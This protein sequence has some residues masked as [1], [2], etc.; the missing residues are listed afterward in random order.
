VRT[1]APTPRFVA[2]TRRT[3]R[4]PPFWRSPGHRAI[5]APWIAIPL[6]LSSPTP[7]SPPS[8]L[9]CSARTTGFS[10]PRLLARVA[11]LDALAATPDFFT[12]PDASALWTEREAAAELVQGVDHL[13]DA[14]HTLVALDALARAEHDD[15]LDA[16]LH[17]ETAALWAQHAALQRRLALT[18]P[19]DTADAIVELSSGAGGIEAMR[20][21]EM[22]RTMYLRWAVRCGF[23]TELL[24]HTDG[25]S[26]GLKS[27]LFVVRGP[28]AYGL[29]RG[30]R[31]IHRLSRMCEGKRQTSFVAMRTTPDV[32][33]SVVVDFAPGDVVRSTMRAGGKGGQNVN[34][35]ETA[36]RLVHRG[37]GI[38]VRVQTE[39]S[40]ADNA[41]IA[42]RLLTA[43][44]AARMQAAQDEDFDATHGAPR[45]A[46]AFGHA[47]RSY[48]L[49][50]YRL[51]RDH[52]TGHT[53]PDA[54]AV[55]HG[56]IDG[57]LDAHLAHRIA[58]VG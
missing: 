57:F 3:G 49:D 35:V 29:L 17:A 48:I 31:G 52:L 8:W 22:L 24:G 40:Q 25:E 28:M 13:L 1:D 20:W 33:R 18:G 47:L 4:T 23:S 34:K 16:T 12:R 44:V 9:R 27:T 46:I 39:R 45:T 32:D 36:V 11:E 6:G 14:T 26:D 2:P 19:D 38:A 56:G 7:R 42:W 58:R 43:R 15:R 54:R 41:R 30:E 10:R 5:T 37:T 21:C 55:L 50:P 51:V 53:E